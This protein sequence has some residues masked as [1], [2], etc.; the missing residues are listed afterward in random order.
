[1]LKKILLWLGGVFVAILV[2]L[3]GVAVWTGYQSA[4]Y[5][6]T[7]VPYI[8]EAIPRI[9]SWDPVTIKSYMSP[10]VMAEI[11]EEQFLETTKAF[12][13]L[14][15]LESVGKPEFTKIMSNA[16]ITEGSGTLVT[17]VVPVKYSNGDAT[18]TIILKDLGE[19][20]EIY[21]L[22]INSMALFK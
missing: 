4:D 6:T 1:M 20:F 7:A 11:P 22:N 10:E 2:L 15:D 16:T 17:Y 3:I 9:S 12:T 5:E 14:G 18:I 19:S 21:N 13:K 8:E